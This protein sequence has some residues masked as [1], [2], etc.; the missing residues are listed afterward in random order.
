MPLRDLVVDLN[1]AIFCV[2]GATSRYISDNMHLCLHN[3]SK[4]ASARAWCPITKVSEMPFGQ[5][6]GA[7]I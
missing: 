7:H 2:R 4:H 1:I 6:R 5:P 3:R